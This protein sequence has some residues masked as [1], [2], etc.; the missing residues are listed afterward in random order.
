M[1]KGAAPPRG[2]GDGAEPHVAKPCRCRRAGK[3]P[4]AAAAAE[5]A[6]PRLATRARHGGAAVKRRQASAWAPSSASSA[7]TISAA[8]RASARVTP[9]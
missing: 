3:V 4:A 8:A 9:R 5:A 2:T 1:K 7:R 6:D